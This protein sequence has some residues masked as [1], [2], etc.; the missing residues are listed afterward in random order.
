MSDCSV[1]YV[2]RN[3]R[4]LSKRFRGH[5]RA[6]KFNTGVSNLG[7]HIIWGHSFE[8]MENVMSVIHKA[9]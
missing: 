6:F 1:V 8:K 4:L 3:G 2:E 7:E 9:I 5:V